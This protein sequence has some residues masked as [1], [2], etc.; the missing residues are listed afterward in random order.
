MT[1]SIFIVSCLGIPG[2]DVSSTFGKVIISFVIIE[3]TAFNFAWGP[4][5]WTIVSA[6]LTI[7]IDSNTNIFRL[8]KWQSDA[9]ATRFTPLL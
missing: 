3:I 9:I 8:L 7:E 5:G 6:L 1:A 2:G 4:L